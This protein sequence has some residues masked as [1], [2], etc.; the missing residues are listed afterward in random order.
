AV[1]MACLCQPPGRERAA[2][3]WRRSPTE[4]GGGSS[5]RLLRSGWTGR[6]SGAGELVGAALVETDQ[7]E[8]L[9]DPAAAVA[10]DHEHDD[11]DRFGDQLARRVGDRAQAEL[12]E[13]IKRARGRLGMNRGDATS[14][15]GA[16]GVEQ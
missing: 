6:E 7:L 15:A 14:V 12:L 8:H 10:D 2:R 16:P 5:G 4:Y 9:F 3:R 11:V 13:P 1:P